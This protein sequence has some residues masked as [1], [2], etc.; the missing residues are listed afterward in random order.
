MTTA[1]P[2][3]G[4]SDASGGQGSLFSGFAAA[5][6][7]VPEQGAASTPPAPTTKTTPPP[8]PAPPLLTPDDRRAFVL[9]NV[10]V[11]R[12]RVDALPGVGGA[13]L[14]EGWQQR[15]EWLQEREPATWGAVLEAEAAWAEVA[16]KFIHEGGTRG[17]F[18]TALRA[19]EAAWGTAA[20]MAA[21]EGT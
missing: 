17:E 9:R 4:G 21:K 5:P 6:A 12:G 8:R 15:I 14:R 19:C 2:V 10:H 18:Y 1:Q 13:P 20:G 3:Q 16:V 7:P 11:L